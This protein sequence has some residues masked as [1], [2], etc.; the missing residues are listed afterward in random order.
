MYEDGNGVP[1]DYVLA[2]MWYSVSAAVGGFPGNHFR[3]QL[4][5]RMTADQ[6]A[7]AQRLAREC[8]KRKYKECD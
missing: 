5:E 7:K 3:D 2:Y 1:Q 8:V 4:E 6:I